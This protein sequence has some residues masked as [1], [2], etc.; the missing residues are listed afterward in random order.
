VYEMNEITNEDRAIWAAEAL[1][2]FVRRTSVEPGNV[3]S[4]FIADLRHL[5]DRIHQEGWDFDDAVEHGT[6]H[7]EEE[8]AEQRLE[9]LGITSWTPGEARLTLA[10]LEDSTLHVTAASTPPGPEAA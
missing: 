7:Y 1:A 2:A 10:K 4:E 5:C 6:R 9:E 3:L 8:V